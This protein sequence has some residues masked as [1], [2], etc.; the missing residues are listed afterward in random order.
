MQKKKK[1]QN[2]KDALPADGA[3]VCMRRRPPPR[4]APLTETHEP[5]IGLL[6]A[7]ARF[8][9]EGP[10]RRRRGVNFTAAENVDSIKRF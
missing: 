7:L 10:C 3:R 5:E 1:Q 6:H 4:R 8:V 9:S 2:L